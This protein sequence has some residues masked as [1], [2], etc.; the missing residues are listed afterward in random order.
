MNTDTEQ[1]VAPFPYF[2]GKR[3]AIDLV[4][5]QFGAV[6]NYVEPFCGSLAMLLGA[7][8]G[9]RTETV[10]DVNGF[11][12]NFWRAVK[13]DPTAVAKW[14]DW[15]VTEIDLEARHGWLVNRGERLKWSL[16]DPDFYDAKI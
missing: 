13:N 9:D 7:P 15:P 10:N 1:L 2:G 12:V 14:A 5:P 8:E 11:V 4:W 3:A 6:D 16:G